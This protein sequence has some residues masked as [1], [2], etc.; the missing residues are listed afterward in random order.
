MANK[1]DNTTLRGDTDISCL[2]N[3]SLTLN[4]VPGTSGQYIAGDCTWRDASLPLAG[5][6]ASTIK[7]V[8]DAT[9]VHA[10]NT[11]TIVV[12]GGANFVPVYS[13]GTNWRIL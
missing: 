4:G 8:N 13:D 1:F 2:L 3:G 9:V 12:G 5:T 10:G 7:F 11:G 6:A